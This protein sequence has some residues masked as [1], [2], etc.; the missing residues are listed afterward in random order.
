MSLHLKSPLK[1]HKTAVFHHFS[2]KNMHQNHEGNESYDIFYSISGADKKT[3]NDVCLFS[4]LGK[5]KIYILLNW[6]VFT[7]SC[8]VKKMKN[9]KACYII[10]KWCFRQYAPRVVKLY[11]HKFVKISI[12]AGKWNVIK[13]Y[14]GQIF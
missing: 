10:Q 13:L 6:F 1:T 3:G 8:F 5:L 11:L 12:S 2:R 14:M 4:S 9:S 7:E